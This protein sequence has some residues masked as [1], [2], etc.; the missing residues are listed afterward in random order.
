MPLALT[1]AI[2]IIAGAVV[3]CTIESR[4]KRQSYRI[5]EEHTLPR[6]F[7]AWIWPATAILSAVV[8]WAIS[9]T[10][11]TLVPVVYVIAVWVM[12]VLAAIDLDVHR[13]PDRIQMPAYPVL[14]ILLALSSWAASDSGAFLRALLAG[15][16]LF[17]VYFVLVLLA[18]GG[19]MGLGDAKL[20]GLLGLLLGWLS[21]GHVIA[22]TLVTFL[23]GGVVAVVLLATRRA[24]AK[25][26]F[27]YGPVML[28]SSVA[29]LVVLSRP[30]VLHF[31]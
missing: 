9:P 8:W 15:S 19:G 2:L 22:S 30:F 6:R 20:A 28:T 24:G 3:G 16:A 14:T 10:R 25:T 18:P 11:P 1:Y 5:E 21:W 23:L 27:A 13:L 29:T 31:S 26:E 7:N 17:A 4:L 12:V